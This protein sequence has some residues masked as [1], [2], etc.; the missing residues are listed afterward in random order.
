MSNNVAEYSG[1]IAFLEW[2]LGSQISLATKGFKKVPVIYSDSALLINQ[3]QGEWMVKKGLYVPYY[4]RAQEMCQR[5]KFELSFCW[6]NREENAEA[7]EWSKKA[8]IQSGIKLRIQPQ[9]IIKRCSMVTAE[10]EETGLKKK[11][12][13]GS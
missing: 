4:L 3:M 6:V 9:P 7:D 12:P 11:S 8:L 1:L 13:E 2:Y 5:H 10:I